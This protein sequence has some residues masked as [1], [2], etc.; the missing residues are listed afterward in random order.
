MCN[1]A[2]LTKDFKLF[3]FRDTVLNIGVSGY[4]NQLVSNFE[5]NRKYVQFF[6]LPCH[7]Y[8]TT[9]NKLAPISSNQLDWLIFKKTDTI[10]TKTFNESWRNWSKLDI[11][12]AWLHD[13]CV[14]FCHFFHFLNYCPI[15]YHC[16]TCQKSPKV[17]S[18]PIFHESGQAVRS[19]TKLPKFLH[20]VILDMLFLRQNFRHLLIREQW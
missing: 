13:I 8:V 14:I 5:K 15:V 3:S 20:D 4:F 10:L 6:F 12:F 2:E 1:V 9:S 18:I 17:S 16:S 19:I 11:G 7:F